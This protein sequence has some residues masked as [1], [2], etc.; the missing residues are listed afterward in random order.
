VNRIPKPASPKTPGGSKLKE[1]KILRD[2]QMALANQL[3]SPN[4]YLAK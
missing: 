4:S 3:S 2:Q 1:K